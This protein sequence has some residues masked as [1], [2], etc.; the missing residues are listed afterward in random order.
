MSPPFRGFL[1]G[2]LHPHESS[3]KVS[4]VESELSCSQDSNLSLLIGQA[5]D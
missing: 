1:R 2:G 5:L 3:G 4:S